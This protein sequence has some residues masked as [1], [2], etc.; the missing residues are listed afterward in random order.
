[1]VRQRRALE[2]LH[3]RVRG[4][5]ACVVLAVSAAANARFWPADGTLVFQQKGAHGASV[6]TANGLEF[7]DRADVPQ[8]VVVRDP[9]EPWRAPIGFLVPANGRFTRTSA[10][11][12]V[13]TT[14]PRRRRCARATRASRR[15]AARCSCGSTSIA[16][17]APGAARWGEDV[18]IVLDGRGETTWRLARGGAGAARGARP[19]RRGGRGRRAR[20]RARDARVASIP[21]D[22]GDRARARIAAARRTRPIARRPSP[23]RCG[24]LSRGDVRRVLV[25]SEDGEASRARRRSAGSATT[26]GPRGGRRRRAAATPDARVHAVRAS[27]PPRATRPSATSCSRSRARPRPSHVLEASGGDARWELEGGELALGDVRAGDERAEVV[28]VTMP[29]WTPGEAFTLHVTARFATSTRGGR[30][31]RR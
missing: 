15:G 7:H 13:A 22:G 25:L 31:S 12:V 8:R 28:R 16:P 10:P 18:A 30:G 4:T 23:R 17:A 3:Y 9:Y 20:R 24:A 2:A 19:R 5:I 11:T 21:G 27:C 1:M 6:V 14:R 29:A 26:L